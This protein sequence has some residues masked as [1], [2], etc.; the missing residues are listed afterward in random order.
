MLRSREPGTAPAD[1]LPQRSTLREHVSGPR[2]FLYFFAAFVLSFGRGPGLHK[3]Q[4]VWLAWYLRHVFTRLAFFSD[5][6]IPFYMLPQHF[7]AYM[8]SNNFILLLAPMPSWLR[9]R[10]SYFRPNACCGFDQ[11]LQ[12]FPPRRLPGLRPRCRHAQF[13]FPCSARVPQRSWGL[14]KRGHFPTYKLQTHISEFS[15]VWWFPSC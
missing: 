6:Q 1:R 10:L 14:P 4:T 5:D 11:A 9:R 2:F 7:N 13:T 3:E 15:Q 12:T 8:Y